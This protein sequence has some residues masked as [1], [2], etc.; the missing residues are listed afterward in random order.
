MAAFAAA[1]EGAIVSSQGFSQ[2]QDVLLDPEFPALDLA[3]RRGQHIDRDAGAWYTLLTDAQ[4]HLEELYRRYGCELIHR[5]DGYF[6]LLP[7]G[8]QLPRRQLAVGDM[9]VG[10][11]LALLYL[12][13]ASVERGGVIGREQLVEQLVSVLGT[14][15]LVGAFVPNRK[16][17]DER[18][19]H[20]LVRAKVA[21]AVRRL[22][23]LGF[24]DVMEADQLR[25]RTALLRFA[26]PVRGLAAP[27][28]A[29]ARLVAQGEVAMAPDEADPAE[30]ELG[31]SEL[32]GP[33][34]AGGDDEDEA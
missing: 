27:A 5:S 33:E 4:P 31:A 25:L 13:P 3:L 7:T 23:A 19:A 21:E 9:V 32:E 30:G 8:D 1:G 11:A 18:V 14:E 10:Q 17:I 24:V 12:D 16:R 28:E 29:L 20:K 2:L 15:T 26:E 34:A 6:Y 22:A